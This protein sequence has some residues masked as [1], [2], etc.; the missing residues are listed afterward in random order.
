MQN[1]IDGAD[2]AGRPVCYFLQLL[3]HRRQFIDLLFYTPDLPF[4]I[5][6]PSHGV[7]Y[8]LFE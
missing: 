6:C 5:P 2:L 4:H 3:L 8:P 1:F 7:Q